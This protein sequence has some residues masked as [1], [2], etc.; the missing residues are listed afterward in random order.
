MSPGHITT[1]DLTLVS[2]ANSGEDTRIEMVASTRRAAVPKWRIARHCYRAWID[3]LRTLPLLSI[4]PMEC[5]IQS[6]S[7]RSEKSSRAC[8]PR[9]SLRASALYLLPRSPG[10]PHTSTSARR[11]A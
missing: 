11:A 7:S 6:L 8:A 5:F 3:S 4:Q 9:D 10:G 1:H 2:L